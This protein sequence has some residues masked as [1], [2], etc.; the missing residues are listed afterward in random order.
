[1]FG[2]TKSTVSVV[3]KQFCNAV[4]DTLFG[5]VVQLPSGPGFREEA[6]KFELRYIRIFCIYISDS[7]LSSNCIISGICFRTRSVL[8]E[9][10]IFPWRRLAI[11]AQVT[12][13]RRAGTRSS[14]WVWPVTITNLVTSALA[15][16]AARTTRPYSKRR[17]CTRLLKKANSSRPTRICTFWPITLSL[18]RTGS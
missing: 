1:M 7:V 18:C 4:V 2:I 9:R 11:A 6:D 17:S 12:P 14:Y 15:S 5:K 16:R 8:L 3:F 10:L 13:T